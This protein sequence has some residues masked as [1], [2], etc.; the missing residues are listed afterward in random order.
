VND[1][2]ERLD[3]DPE[4]KALLRR[5]QVP[6][7][8]ASLERRLEASLRL[9]AH[10][11]WWKRLL[12]ARLSVPVP[13]AALVLLLLLA[14]SLL[15]VRITHSEPLQP[16]SIPSANTPGA[17]VVSVWNSRQGPAYVTHAD[18]SGFRPPD[19]IEARIIKQKGTTQ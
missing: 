16:A 11:P 6:P 4:W 9:G 13:V 3:N 15:K 14:V 18:W 12:A 2:M 10:E 7:P 1:P 17:P 19:R 5:W 8:T